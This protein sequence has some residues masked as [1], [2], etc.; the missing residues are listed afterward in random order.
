MNGYIFSMAGVIIMLFSAGLAL[1]AGLTRKIFPVGSVTN[2]IHIQFWMALIALLFPFI[3]MAMNSLALPSWLNIVFTGIITVI[4]STIAGLGF[5]LAAMNL[6]SRMPRLV[7]QVYSAQFL[8][9]AFG[10]L[11]TTLVF[12]P[13]FGMV[14]SCMILVALNVLSVM[15]QAGERRRSL[16][17]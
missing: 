17:Q 14:I 10:A 1:G 2:Y 6:N 8:G 5:S 12:L 7:S 3:I 13:L 4:V 11:I 9:S 16:R 15:L